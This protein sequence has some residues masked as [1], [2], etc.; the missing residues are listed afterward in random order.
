VTATYNYNPLTQDQYTVGAP[1]SVM[2]GLTYTFDAKI[3]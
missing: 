2:L 3:R 1:L